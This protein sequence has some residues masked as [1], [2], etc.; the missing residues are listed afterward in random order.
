MVM[1]ASKSLSLQ[2][3]AKISLHGW[4][5]HG[6]TKAIDLYLSAPP[7]ELVIQSLEVPAMSSSTFRF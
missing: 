7:T 4:L 1:D 5:S 6:E 3:W 2:A